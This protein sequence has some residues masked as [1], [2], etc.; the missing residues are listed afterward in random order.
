MSLRATARNSVCYCWCWVINSST[1]RPLTDINVKDL[2]EQYDIVACQQ[3]CQMY[4]VYLASVWGWWRHKALAAKVSI[5]HIQNINTI[6]DINS[7]VC[8]VIRHPSTDTVWRRWQWTETCSTKDYTPWSHQLEHSSLVS[9]MKQH[10]LIGVNIAGEQLRQF[11]RSLGY[12]AVDC[13]GNILVADFDNRRIL[14]LDNHLSLRRVIIDQHQLNYKWP[15][16]LCYMIHLLHLCRTRTSGHDE[17]VWLPC[18]RQTCDVCPM[19]VYKT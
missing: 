18:S 5:W 10:Q 3:T 11:S 15:L 4:G 6:S 19:P 17:I 14:L 13:R 7:P 12:I 16:R 1:H 9:T 8:D 2:R